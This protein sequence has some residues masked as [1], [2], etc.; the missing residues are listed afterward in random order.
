MPAILLVRF[1]DYE[2]S[3]SIKIN[4][5]SVVPISPRTNQWDNNGTVCSRTQYPLTRAF[6]IS[7][8]K[9]QGLT[10]PSVVLNLRNRDD[11]SGQSYVALSRV[12]AIEH[13]AFEVGFSYDHFPSKMP[14][15]VMKRI[16]DSQ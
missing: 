7:V 2:G 3:A 13:V 16:H 4:N 6:A 15:N 5:V 1:D 10:L 12:R 8:H 9:S 11:C 14:E